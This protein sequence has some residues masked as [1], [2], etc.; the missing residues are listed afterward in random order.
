MDNGSQRTR[1]KGISITRK[2]ISKAKTCSSS[3]NS[4]ANEKP[5]GW[6]IFVGHPDPATSAD[7]LAAHLTECGITV[8]H[9]KQ[10]EHKEVWHDK[11][12]AFHVVIDYDSID[13]VFEDDEFWPA[14]TNVTDWYLTR[15]PKH[16]DDESG[17]I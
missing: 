4:A 8:I 13:H 1:E 11:F 6:H 5:K 9:Y 7:E 2:I 12:A 10:I 16:G 14:G 17:H 3:I 15:Q